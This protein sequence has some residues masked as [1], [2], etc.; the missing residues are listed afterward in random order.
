MPRREKGRKK[1]EIAAQDTA[2]KTKPVRERKI[3][4]GGN[5]NKRD[6]QENETQTERR[7]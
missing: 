4:R 6:G 1:K 5:R 2:T 7:L 3:K